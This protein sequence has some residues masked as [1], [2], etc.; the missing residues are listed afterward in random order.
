MTP[1]KEH[2]NFPVTETKEMEIHKIAWQRIQN[3]S[4]KEAQLQKNRDRQFN[5]IRKSIN[6]QNKKLNKEIDCKKKK[7][8][9]IWS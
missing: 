7:S 9:Q 2:N 1:P 3:N 8:N 5:K 4:F 6:E